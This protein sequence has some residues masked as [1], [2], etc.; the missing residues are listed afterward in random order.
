MSQRD[1]ATRPASRRTSTSPGTS[2][3][4]GARHFGQTAGGHDVNSDTVK[5]LPKETRGRDQQLPGSK[6]LGMLNILNPSDSRPRDSHGVHDTPSQAGQS[7]SAYS[8]WTTHGATRHPAPGHSASASYPGTPAGNLNLGPPGSERQSPTVGYPFPNM[9]EPRKILSPK[10][11]RPSSL[12]QSSGFPREFEPRSHNYVPSVSPA[13]RPYEGEG[14]D[15][16]RLPSLHQT[17]RIAHASG[18]QSLTPPSRSLSQPV[19]RAPDVS[20]LQGQ[21]G[22]SREVHGPP[23][24]SQFQHGQLQG[25][26]PAVSRPPEGSS[27]WT[28]VMRRSGMG[29][30]PGGME[31]Q[32]AYMTLPGSDTPIPVQVD[33]SQASRKADEKR[34]RNAKA[35]TRHRRKKKTLQEENVRQLQ[36]LKDERQQMSD[37][38]DY[39]RR[40]RDFYRDERNRLREIVSRTPGIHQHAHG[41]RSPTPSRS[42][43]S[44]T[45]HSPVSQHL[46]PTTSQG[47]VSDPNSADRAVQLPKMEERPEFPGPGLPPGVA[48]SGLASAHG[49]PYGVPPRPPSAA[50]S[51]GGERLPPLR[52]ME[53][54]PPTVQHVGPGQAHERDPRTG[55]WR[56]VPP[57]QVETGWATGPRK[58][59][60]HQIHPW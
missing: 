32:Q 43:G 10:V 6:S 3:E 42:V 53:G 21:A 36:E 55:Q 51:G 59:G 29:S 34:Q 12:S 48:P 22:P 9:S 18:S 37:E 57:R 1:P 7:T 58:S 17:P 60:D 26:L 30:G 15:E 8:S 38:I 13:K 28:E 41:P 16:P 19:S 2:G 47:Y 45:D 35:S 39:L 56:P 14:L 5:L 11:A 49:Q 23:S 40:Q 27:T 24:H 25:Q 50:S 52:A 31:G 4:S 20:L 54:P 46:M 33:Y 44:H